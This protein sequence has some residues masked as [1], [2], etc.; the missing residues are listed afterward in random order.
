MI[1]LYS[2][3]IFDT[4][5]TRKTAT[6]EGVF[7]VMQKCL[8]DMEK[9]GKF[10]ARLCNNFYLIRQQAEMV[11]RNTYQIGEVRDVTLPQIYEAVAMMEDLTAEQTEELVKLEST[12]EM[13]NSIP[14][15]ANIEIVKQLVREGKRVVLISNMYL[16]QKVIRDMLVEADPVFTDMTIY[17]SGDLGKT[18]GTRT[19]YQYVKDK[20]KVEFSEW[21]H[22]GDHWEL[23]VKLPQSMGIQAE[24]FHSAELL[25]WEKALLEKSK[26]S[27]QK[28]ILMGISRNI[29][30]VLAENAEIVH[31]SEI[32]YQVGYGFSAQ[33]LLPYVLWVLKRSVQKDIHKLFFIARDGYILKKIADILIEEYQYPLETAYLYGSRKAWRLPSV[34]EE[35]DIHELFRWNYQAH[36]GSFERLAEILGMT[37][38][39]LGKFLPCVKPGRKLSAGLVNESIEILSRNQREIGSFLYKKFQG[40]REAVIGYLQQEIGTAPDEYA[41]VDLI[42]SGYTQ[43]CLANLLGEITPKTVRTFFYR[44][45]I[46]ASAERNINYSYFSNR[47]PMSGVMEALCGAPHGQTA[48][49]E[50]RGKRWEPVLGQDEGQLLEAYGYGDYLTGIEEYTKCFSVLYKK[51]APELDDLTASADYFSYLVTAENK[52]LYDYIA[53]MP[54]GMIGNTDQVASFAPLISDKELKKMYFW[55]KNERKENHYSGY[56]LEFSLKRL[57]AKQRKKLVFYEQHS[58]CGIVKCLRKHVSEERIDASRYELLAPQIVIYGAGKRG[59]LLYQQLTTQRKHLA[60]LLRRSEA[61]L[62]QVVSW[63]DKDF[64]SYRQEG[65]P[66]ESPEWLSGGEYQQ[67]VI[68]VASKELAQE[69]MTELIAA[70]IEAGKLFWLN[71]TAKF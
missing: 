71:P 70:G 45:D 49:Y 15:R 12:L 16:P 53:D 46:S 13:E 33:L 61:S 31:Q 42:G 55:C 29:R 8:C 63:V 65:L 47:L 40:E 23:D 9:N 48:H 62:P 1:R 19:L 60:R 30:N 4:L 69:I 54:Y 52:E 34:N 20:E 14:L 67:V 25:P 41:F 2:F 58:D 35:L 18:K 36:I 68:A 27:V 10:P 37:M 6:P 51:D 11:A 21:K 22:V 28:Q 38:E 59:K 26:D 7:A 39:E 3:D 43:K 44:L 17:I 32:S 57:T 56:S 66:V 64:A 50:M 5:I 24:H